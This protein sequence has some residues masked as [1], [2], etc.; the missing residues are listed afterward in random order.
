MSVLKHFMLFVFFPDFPK[1][2]RVKITFNYIQYLLHKCA[3][4]IL[5]LQV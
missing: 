1:Y 5:D 4:S 3:M 2:Y